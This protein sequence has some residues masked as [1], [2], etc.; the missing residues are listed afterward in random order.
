MS[1]ELRKSIQ[2]VFRRI[3]ARDKIRESLN[4]RP[5]C[6]CGHCGRTSWERDCDSMWYCFICGNRGF[7]Q[8]GKF[9]QTSNR[10]GV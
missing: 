4:V 9:V 3:H 10:R 1:E 2:E 7:W 5:V 8:D 6:E